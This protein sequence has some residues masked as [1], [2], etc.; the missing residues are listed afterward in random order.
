MNRQRAQSDALKLV[1]T[2]TVGIAATLVVVHLERNNSASMNEFMGSLAIWAFVGSTLLAILVILLDRLR[3]PDADYIVTQGAAAGWTA[4]HLLD[5]LRLHVLAAARNNEGVIR[6]MR[7][8]LTLQVAF[9]IVS[10]WA[11]IV[12]ILEVQS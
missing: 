5:E 8:A 4:E 11:A 9:A 6:D 3:E 1:A 2:F 10:G 12:A 7:I